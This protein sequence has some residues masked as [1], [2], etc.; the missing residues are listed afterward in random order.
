M[1][2]GPRTDSGV[3]DDRMEYAYRYGVSGW[4]L[5]RRRWPTL[6]LDGC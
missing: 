2:P 4:E 5:D 6:M 3:Y 1:R